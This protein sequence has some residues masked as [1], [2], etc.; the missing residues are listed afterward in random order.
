MICRFESV[1]I[2]WFWTLENSF[3]LDSE[4]GAPHENESRTIRPR[5]PKFLSRGICVKGNLFP[6]PVAQMS[7]R[8]GSMVKLSPQEMV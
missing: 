1:L 4:V 8:D 3:V 7:Q 5:V 6:T 2:F